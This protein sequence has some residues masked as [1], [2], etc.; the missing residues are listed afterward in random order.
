MD[1]LLYALNSENKTLYDDEAVDN[2][3]VLDLLKQTASAGPSRPTLEMEKENKNLKEYVFF[4]F[5]LFFFLKL[6][7]LIHFCSSKKFFLVN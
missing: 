7:S 3:L 1:K 2:A 5:I 6:N 4:F